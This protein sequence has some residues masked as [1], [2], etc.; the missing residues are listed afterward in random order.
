MQG[1]EREN[2]AAAVQPSRQLHRCTHRAALLCLCFYIVGLGFET[3]LELTEILL[4]L[5]PYC[6][7]KDV[8]HQTQSIQKH[9]LIF[10][11]VF[12]C[13]FLFCFV[14][15]FETGSHC[16]SLAVLEIIL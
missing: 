14:G 7:V 1:A 13:C 6:S 2:Q 11:F 9:F 8:R 12:L 3:G 16:V 10:G 4:P 15:V 5:H